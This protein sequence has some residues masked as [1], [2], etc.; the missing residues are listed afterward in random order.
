[1]EEPSIPVTKGKANLEKATYCRV[2]TTQH[3]EMS[4]LWRRG[5]MR[6]VMNRYSTVGFRAVKLLCM[7]ACESMSPDSCPNPQHVQDK[8]E[9]NMSYGLWVTRM[10]LCELIVCRTCRHWWGS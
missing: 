10:Y 4:K 5:K 9:P 8:P 2:P 1:M 3:L 7:T 6:G